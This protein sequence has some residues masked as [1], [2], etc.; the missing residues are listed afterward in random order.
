MR[1]MKDGLDAGAIERIVQAFAGA[2]PGFEGRAFR[3]R[4]LAGLER[5][6]LKQRVDHIRDALAACLPADPLRARRVVLM[7]CDRFPPGNP[8]DPLR[9]FAAWPVIQWVPLALLDHP[10]EALETLR[11]ITGLFSA[12]FAI[13][14]F[15]ARH[16]DLALPLLEEWTRDPSPAVRRLVSEGSRPRLPW[17]ERL[18]ALQQDPT[19]VLP[20]LEALR[21]DPAVTRIL[22]V[23]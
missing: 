17:G 23:F 13:R 22:K 15:L 21:D 8:D 18:R 11:R 9:G 7:A 14:P 16:W 1:A 2:D 3:Q 19:P 10:L 5:L 20:L 6:E 12:E 4:A